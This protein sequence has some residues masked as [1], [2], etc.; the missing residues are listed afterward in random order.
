V[1]GAIE[2]ICQRF[3]DDYGLARHRDGGSPRTSCDARS[4]ALGFSLMTT[5]GGLARQAFRLRA[6]LVAL[7]AATAASMPARG[8]DNAA[9]LELEHQFEMVNRDAS[10]L[11]I[12]EV[13][14]RACRKG[15]APLARRLLDAGASVYARDRDGTMPLGYA[16]QSGQTAVVDL[17]LEQGA[18][19]DAR[20]LAGSTALYAAA[21]ND[22]TAV[23]DRLLAKGA[24]PNLAGRS[25]VTVL[26]AAAFKG[27]KPI[28][29]S[30]LANGS[31]PNEVD[32]TGKSAIIYAAALGFTPIVQRLL[33][34]GVPIN[35][36]Y[37]NDLTVLMWAAGYAD[38]AGVLD[39]ENVVKLLLDHNADI[40]AVDD[41]GRTALMIAAE[42]DHPTI[43]DILLKRGADR[44]ITD[45][46]G[47]TA[48]DLATSDGVRQTLRTP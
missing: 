2:R 31:K 45:K 11:Q 3:P 22:R 5:N 13:L 16:A 40:N 24:D 27:N 30:L 4:R 6:I 36:R 43:V 46:Q 38:G 41:R 42:L 8:A 21:E 12:N 10:S 32:A 47:K 23:V 25:G 15:C 26:A 37:G 44:S 17:L 1:R 7:V 35:A 39:A 19:I 20:N 29:D 18:P 34:A 28:V 33:D 48:L 14:F 9:C